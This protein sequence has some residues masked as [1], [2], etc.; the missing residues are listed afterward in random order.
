[1]TIKNYYEHTPKSGSIEQIIILLHGVG[2]NGQDLISLAP[3]WQPYVPQ[4]VFISPD[5]PFACDMVPA[6]YPNSYQWF[7]LQDRDPQVL[8]QG[9][10][11]VYPILERFIEEKLAQ[12]NLGYDRLALVGFSQGTMTSLYVAPH[13]KKKIA[14]VLAY[15]G[16]L[17]SAGEEGIK[18]KPPIHL[19][20]GEADD[21]VPVRA[22]HFAKEVLEK[23]GFSVTGYTT[24]RLMHSI[25]MEG[26]QSGGEFLQQIFS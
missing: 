5:A 18:Q 12:Y 20:H 7:S 13:L 23:D 14:G 16:A 19:I 6:G 8:L 4:A 1:M 15:S 24:P 9:L 22:W 2:S 17:L 26:I 25:D 11:T 3:M 10:K 21:V